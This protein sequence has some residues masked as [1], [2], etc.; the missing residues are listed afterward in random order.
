M[1]DPCKYNLY[2]YNPCKYNRAKQPYKSTTI[3]ANPTQ[4]QAKTLFLLYAQSLVFQTSIAVTALCHLPAPHLAGFQQTGVQHHLELW[5]R[6]TNAGFAGH[7]LLTTTWEEGA[8][9]DWK[10]TTARL[11]SCICIQLFCGSLAI[12]R[13]RSCMY[14]EFF[15]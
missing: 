11:R 1:Y 4:P 14:N 6:W 2:T 9:V 15:C 5:P 10:M 7:G 12:A 13:I 3:P 8:G